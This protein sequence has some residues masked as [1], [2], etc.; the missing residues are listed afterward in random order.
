[1]MISNGCIC[2]SYA[3]EASSAAARRLRRYETLDSMQSVAWHVRH[4]QTCDRIAPRL[5]FRL[6]VSLTA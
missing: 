1:M 4:D 2:E 6:V 3:D 5:Y